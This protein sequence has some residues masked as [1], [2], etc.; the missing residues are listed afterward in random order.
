MATEVETIV[1]GA[2]CD[3]RKRRAD[4][5]TL[6]VH[7]CCQWPI[8]HMGGV[9]LIKKS[10][11][12]IAKWKHTSVKSRWPVYVRMCIHPYDYNRLMT[13]GYD[14]SPYVFVLVMFVQMGSRKWSRARECEIRPGNCLV[15]P[16]KSSWTDFLG[17]SK[18]LLICLSFDVVFYV[19]IYPTAPELPRLTTE[20]IKND[21]CH[22]QN[23]SFTYFFN[24]D[25]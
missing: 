18:T 6:A 4:R 12:Y 17:L 5:R 24:H 20:R 23:N 14:S 19:L 16:F 2:L 15:R 22:M 10:N 3:S 21:D 25:N 9:S 1:D 11:K 13:T 8:K 7:Q